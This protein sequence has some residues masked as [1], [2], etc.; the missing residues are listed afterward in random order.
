MRLLLSLDSPSFISFVFSL[1]YITSRI[2]FLSLLKKHLIVPRLARVHLRGGPSRRPF[3]VARP[4]R[5]PLHEPKRSSLQQW[6][7]CFPL[8][9]HYVRR[10]L[11]VHQRR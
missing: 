8:R 10:H 5:A 9:P 7:R 4:L 11:T 3:H 6:P 2:T 1:P